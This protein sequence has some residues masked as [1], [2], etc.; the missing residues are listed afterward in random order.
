MY[1]QVLPAQMLTVP[2]A[3]VTQSAE[4]FRP[5]PESEYVRPLYPITAGQ[6][7]SNTLHDNETNHLQP[8][9]TR[10]FIEQHKPVESFEG[11]ITLSSLNRATLSLKS[12]MASEMDWAVKLL[13]RASYDLA[14]DFILERVTGLAE[15][16]LFMVQTGLA[17]LAAERDGRAPGEPQFPNGE[18]GDRVIKRVKS[19]HD[20]FRHTERGGQAARPL[21]AALILRNL[22]MQPENAKYIGRLPVTLDILRQGL[23]LE[24]A[25]HTMELRQYC[26]ELSE[27]IV[28]FILITSEEDPLY[29][30]LVELLRSDDRNELLL[31][32]RALSRLSVADEHNRLLQ[33]INSPVV[34]RLIQYL[35]LEDEELLHA[36]TAFFFQFTTYQ[37]NT[38]SLARNAEAPTLLRRLNGLTMWNA[39]ERTE[40]LQLTDSRT[41]VRPETPPPA[42]PPQLS[43][44][45][46]RE[47]LTFQEPERAIHWMRACFEEDR[48]QSV[49]QILLWQSY[50]TL[51]TPYSQPQQ[52][53]SVV[54]S[55]KP[56]LQA[57]DVIKMVGNA[58]N[59]ATAMVVNHP[60]EGQKFIV[61]GIR[62][63]ESPLAPSGKRYTTCQWIADAET[64]APCAAPF[65]NEKDLHTHVMEKHLKAQEGKPLLC[66][67]QGCSK[68]A[69]G[70]EVDR[71]VIAVHL[72]LHTSDAF[73]KKEGV[74]TIHGTK[75]SIT[76][77]HTQQDEKGEPKGIALTAALTLRNILRANTTILASES[78]SVSQLKGDL[79]NHLTLNPVVAQQAGEVL[80]AMK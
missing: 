35:Q 25:A 67:W 21:E 1:Q 64:K 56:L 41:I 66:C 52:N 69:P 62:C 2:M 4:Y 13:T 50:R 45:I 18:D 9:V 54:V 6:F 31:G 59:G 71:K 14:N 19:T 28:P 26:I 58:F 46:V 77:E 32:L 44:E 15:T 65:A 73:P 7:G 20:H 42:N 23:S 70:G 34:S 30:T 8:L 40:Q 74:R 38:A 47:L 33:D 61:R 3:P 80:A 53:G 57:A 16:L 27:A 39:Q 78:L 36:L 11:R 55:G 24:E 51:F 48:E 72:R 17:T 49:T 10:A 79:L 63:R 22:T 12:G 5:P 37:A 43:D 68:F 60:T 29:M 76:N 75:I